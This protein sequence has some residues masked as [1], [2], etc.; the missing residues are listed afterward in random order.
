ML[1][2]KKISK[3]NKVTTIRA[4]INLLKLYLLA[5]LENDYFFRCVLYK[6]DEDDEAQNHG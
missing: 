3:Q 4:L 2:K 6:G 5:R 1:I